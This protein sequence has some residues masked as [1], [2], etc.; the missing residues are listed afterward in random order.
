[1]ADYI[2]L[3]LVKDEQ[4]DLVLCTAP[5]WTYFEENDEVQYALDD[6]KLVNANVRKSA[7]IQ[8]DSD[9][10]KLIEEYTYSPLKK[11]VKK[12]KYENVYWRNDNE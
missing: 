6:G 12:V 7:T 3:V 5:A 2:D 8:S 11:I 9:V 10:F 1:M 4:N